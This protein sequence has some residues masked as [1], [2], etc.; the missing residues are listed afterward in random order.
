MPRAASARSGRPLRSGADEER[1]T[2]AK[3]DD[4]LERLNRAGVSDYEISMFAINSPG[5]MVAVNASA[6]DVAAETIARTLKESGA[7]EVERA[8]GEWNG[9]TWSDFD[10]LRPPQRIDTPA[11]SSKASALPSH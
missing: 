2:E 4:A 11:P 10:P 7:V 5:T 9:G 8:E 1:P 6:S 3:A